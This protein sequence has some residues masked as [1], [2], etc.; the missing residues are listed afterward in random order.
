[1]SGAPDRALWFLAGQ[2][3]AASVALLDQTPQTGSASSQQTMDAAVDSV[4]AELVRLSDAVAAL[5]G[6]TQ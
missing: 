5:R 6:R 1:M 2:A 3:A 4:A